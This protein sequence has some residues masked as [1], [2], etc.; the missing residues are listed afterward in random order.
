MTHQWLSVW[1]I[2]RMFEDMR[3]RVLGFSN[4]VL[5]DAEYSAYDDQPLDEPGEWGDLASFREAAARS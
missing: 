4:A 3:H 5:V 2:A 1:F